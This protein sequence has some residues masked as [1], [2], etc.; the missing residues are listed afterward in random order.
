M[1]RHGLAASS[2]TA[3]RRGHERSRSAANGAPASVQLARPA[4]AS[5]RRRRARRTTGPSAR[6]WGRRPR[7]SARRARPT[8]AGSSR[9]SFGEHVDPVVDAHRRP[10]DL[11][12]DSPVGS[13]HHARHRHARRRGRRPGRPR[14]P[15]PRRRS[16][17]TKGSLTAIRAAAGLQP[18]HLALLAAGHRALEER[19]AAARSAG[20]TRRRWRHRRGVEHVGH[21]SRP[22]PG[23]AD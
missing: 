1:A 9:R 17:S 6:R 16:T 8:S 7:G 2:S 10:A 21:R 14:R 23:T 15:S 3:T 19:A 11:D 20:R 12:Q 22:C 18:P 5:G 13:P 4:R